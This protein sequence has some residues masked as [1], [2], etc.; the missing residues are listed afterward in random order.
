M[1]IDIKQPLTAAATQKGGKVLRFREIAAYMG[2]DDTKARIAFRHL[3]AARAAV[4]LCTGEWMM[5][6]SMPSPVIKRGKVLQM[7]PRNA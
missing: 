5:V 4:E 2:A 1:T 3:A 7:P 6:T